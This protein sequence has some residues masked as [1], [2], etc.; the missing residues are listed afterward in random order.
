MLPIIVA[1]SRPAVAVLAQSQH[2][3]CNTSVDLHPSITETPRSRV[4]F[5]STVLLNPIGSLRPSH[6]QKPNRH[7]ARGTA[8]RIPSRDFLLWRFSNAGHKP[9]SSRRRPS[10]A[11]IRKPSQY[12][13]SHR[14]IRSLYRRWLGAS[15]AFR[16]RTFFF[17]LLLLFPNIVFL[18]HRNEVPDLHRSGLNMD[19]SK[20]LVL[21]KGWGTLALP[22]CLECRSMTRTL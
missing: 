14:L 10:R 21:A 7:R 18:L 6:A 8:L 3:D 15:G 13:K 22:I 19:T 16:G 1:G 2:F 12:R 9:R 4:S 20:K 17:G 5:A 11:G